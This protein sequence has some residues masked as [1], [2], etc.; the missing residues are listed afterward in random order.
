MRNLG[1]LLH[2]EHVVQSQNSG[3]SC[4][5]NSD[6]KEKQATSRHRRSFRKRKPEVGTGSASR[7]CKR[8]TRGRRWPCSRLSGESCAKSP[9]GPVLCGKSRL[10]EAP[11]SLRVCTQGCWQENLRTLN[12]EDN[13]G[14]SMAHATR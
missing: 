13:L 4:L 3:K 14:V 7:K 5:R 8:P 10:L 9:E 11:R 12:P 6:L 2:Q 1:S